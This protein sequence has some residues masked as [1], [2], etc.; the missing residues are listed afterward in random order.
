MSW[1]V[2]HFVHPGLL[3]GL[4]LIAI[5][6]LI[7]LFNRVRYR[8]IEWAAMTFLLRALKRSQRR[9]RIE[10]FIL[11]LLRCL[12][13][14]CFVFALARPRG[15]PIAKLD[16]TDARKNIVVLLDTS[17]S[18]GYQIGSD[19]RQTVLERERRAAKEIVRQLRQVDRVSII[20]FDEQPRKI[21][22]TPRSVDPRTQK[23]ILDEIDSLPEMQMT[24]RGTDYGAALHV[25]PE[26]LK[27]FDAGPDGQPP[28]PELPPSPKT[29][30]LITDNQ[31]SG[32]FLGGN[33]KDPT[34]RGVAE[35]VRKLGATMFVVD[36]G[37]DDPKN[38][39]IVSLDTREPIVGTNLPCY[40][41]CTVKNWGTL[42]PA[43]GPKGENVA[44]L[45][46][47]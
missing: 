45:T 22:A 13:L 18:T 20:A 34:I 21:Y 36:C 30:F 4:A 39:G 2:T 17:W 33:L 40:I 8:Q 47:E 26:V 25:L 10:N 42:A 12:V 11:L 3:A 1:I 23:E 46:L 28:P 6:I 5:P 7:W 9:L 37:P 16:E 35:D 19:A 14:A 15:Q 31:R 44:G 41:E 27:R 32:L 38:V 29:V 43:R 24:A